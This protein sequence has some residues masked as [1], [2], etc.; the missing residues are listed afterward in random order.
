MPTLQ[1]LRGEIDRIDDQIHDLLIRRVQIGQEVAAAKGPSSGPFFLP[2]READVIRR[3]IER[4]KEPLRREALIRFWY[5]IMKSNLHLQAAI[6]A[7]VFDPTDDADILDQARTFCGALTPV[8]RLGSAK[9]VFDAV[10]AE[11][12]EVGILPSW[13]TDAGRWWRFWCEDDSPS[14]KPRIVARLPFL[15]PDNPDA[16]S[17]K[18]AFVI[19]SFDPRPSGHDRSLY[20]IRGEFSGPATRLDHDGEWAL[21]EIDGHHGDDLPHGGDHLDW[22]YLGAYPVP[23]S[24]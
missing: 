21:I 13:T 23:V 20:A 10:N 19:T 4:N 6:S 14:V 1:D 5:E 7:V 2:N 9:D 17:V 11:T 22:R 16:L 18:D 24:Y 12:S 3:L 15:E 8:T